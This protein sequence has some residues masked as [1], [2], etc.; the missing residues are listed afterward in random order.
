MGPAASKDT[1]QLQELHNRFQ[2]VREVPDS[3]VS[4]LEEK[5]THRPYLL[6]EIT[7]NDREEFNRAIS[8]VT[9]KKREL[10][11]QPHVAP[12][13]CTIVSNSE[14]FTKTE[15]NFCSN[16]YKLYVL[17][18]YPHKTLRDEID[19]RQKRNSKFQ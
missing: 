14:Y 17:F 9:I 1:Q 11:G 8:K 16:F 4:F 13:A 10:E 3:N 19:D 5:E 15:D 18:E 12:L 7:F 6:K 2:V